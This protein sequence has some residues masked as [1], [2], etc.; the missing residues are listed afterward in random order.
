MSSSPYIF[1][2]IPKLPP[3]YAL[4]VMPF[5]MSGLMSG[6]ICMVNL[7][8][9][10]GW[11]TQVLRAWPTTWL[12]AWAVAFPTVMLVIPLVKRITVRLVRLP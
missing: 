2:R 1:G 8:R 9:A 6:I 12:L 4:I 5:F 7:L 3:K 11:T 10:M